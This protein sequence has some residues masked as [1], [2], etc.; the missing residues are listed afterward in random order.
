MG[1]DRRDLLK[2]LGGLML[3]AGAAAR[4]VTA[5][6]IKP[7]PITYQPL[8][9]RSGLRQIGE[10]Y[11]LE[12]IA[13]LERFAAHPVNEDLLPT[14]LSVPFATLPMNIYTRLGD[15]SYALPEPKIPVLADMLRN[16]RPG[17]LDPAMQTL[18]VRQVRRSKLPAELTMV[19]DI[20][21]RVPNIAKEVR[22]LGDRIVSPRYVVDV[23]EGKCKGGRSWNHLAAA[24]LVSMVYGAVDE[25]VAK[26]QAAKDSL[27]NGPTANDPHYTYFVYLRPEIWA[28]REAYMV[29]C[30]LHMISAGVIYTDNSGV[31]A[32]T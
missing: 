14:A 12:E 20:P 6:D 28:K 21:R 10:Q 5:A 26:W 27:A 8:G 16:P 29:E 19:E 11:L 30:F 17:Q 23:D 32:L 4:T 2:G 13:E 3:G 1:M 31:P 24:M 25:L 7:L 9:E 15:A 18:F 22:V